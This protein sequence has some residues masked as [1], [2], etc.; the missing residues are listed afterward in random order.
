MTIT[1]SKLNFPRIVCNNLIGKHHAFHHR[2]G[3]GAIIMI[4]GVV[5]AKSLGHHEYEAVA[6]I[7][8]TLGYGLHGIGLIPFVEALVDVEA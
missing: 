8:D 5:I 2:A 1:C 4:C 6:L 7:G 3:V